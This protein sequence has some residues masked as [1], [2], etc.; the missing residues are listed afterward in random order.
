M[1]Q[2]QEK[3]ERYPCGFWR[4]EMGVFAWVL[5]FVLWVLRL[6]GVLK[7]ESVWREAVVGV[8]ARLSSPSFREKMQVVVSH[9]VEQ[10]VDM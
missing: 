7:G 2:E 9:L 5:G 1:H 3:E 8:A 6:E 10:R 4:V